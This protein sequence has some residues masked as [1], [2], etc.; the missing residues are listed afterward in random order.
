MHRFINYL[1]ILREVA[2][3]IDT[4]A[5]AKLNDA[6]KPYLRPSPMLT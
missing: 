2:R 6:P 5:T 4:I 3:N 1:A